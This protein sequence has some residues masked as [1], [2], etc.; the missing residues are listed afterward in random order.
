MTAWAGGIA[1][2]IYQGKHRQGVNGTDRVRR[3][4]FVTHAGDVGFEKKSG[5][6]Q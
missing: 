4:E 1:G 6:K 5:K 2:E 3:E